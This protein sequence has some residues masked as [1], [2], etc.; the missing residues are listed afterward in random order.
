M[1]EQRVVQEVDT[2]EKSREATDKRSTKELTGIPHA[3]LC[4]KGETYMGEEG[5]QGQNITQK[6]RSILK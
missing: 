3:D 4:E 1:E 6:L 2:V 5:G